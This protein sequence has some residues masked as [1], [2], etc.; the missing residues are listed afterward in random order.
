MAGHHP[1]FAGGEARESKLAPAGLE[2]GIWA[3]ADAENHFQPPSSASLL[4]TFV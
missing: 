1:A 2:L 3:L 4:S